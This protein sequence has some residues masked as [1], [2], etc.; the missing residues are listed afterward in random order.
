MQKETSSKPSPS[1][2]FILNIFHWQVAAPLMLFLSLKSTDQALCQSQQWTLVFLPFLS[3]FIL[4]SWPR[5][6][7]NT[8]YNTTSPSFPHFCLFLLCLHSTSRKLRD[9]AWKYQVSFRE[10]DRKAE[11]IYTWRSFV[12]DQGGLQYFQVLFCS[13]FIL[14]FLSLGFRALILLPDGF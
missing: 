14:F 1:T 13:L 2:P 4:H 10:Q 8:R 6:N 12:P 7:L 9:W 5:I 3:D 11:N